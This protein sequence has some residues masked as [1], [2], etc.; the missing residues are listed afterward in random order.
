MY[1]IIT[2]HSIY[3]ILSGLKKKLKLYTIRVFCFLKGNALLTCTYLHRP[4]FKSYLYIVTQ[5]ARYSQINGRLLIHEPSSEE[6]DDGKYQCTA[7]NDFGQ[8]LSNTVSLSF[9]CK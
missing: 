5:D 4:T 7:F 3:V 1:N 2:L 9:G 8:I 6:Q